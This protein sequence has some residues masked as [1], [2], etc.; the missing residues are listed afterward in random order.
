MR[1]ETRIGNH[2]VK[3]EGRER[4]DRGKTIKTKGNKHGRKKKK[5]LLKGKG[6]NKIC[7]KGAGV[8]SDVNGVFGGERGEQVGWVERLDSK[9]K[10]G[11]WGGIQKKSGERGKERSMFTDGEGNKN[12]NPNEG[13]NKGTCRPLCC[14]GKPRSEKI[15]WKN[16]FCPEEE[17]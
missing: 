7:I 12:P 15:A 17:L 8:F 16:G 4:Y 10:R 13:K 6:G 11:C 1:K 5:W 2:P 3:T 14:S 9:L